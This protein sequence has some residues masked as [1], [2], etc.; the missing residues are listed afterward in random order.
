M[1][2]EMIIRPAVKEDAVAAARLLYDALHDVAHQLTGAE[3]EQEAV[4]VLEWFFRQEEG[5]LSYRQ[6]LVG[7][8]EGTVAGIIVLYGGDEAEAL[9]RPMIE[10]LRALKND[11]SITLDKETDED[12]F[13]ID[14]LSVSPQYGRRGVG[15][16]LMKAARERARERGY[17]KISLAVVTT[18]HGAHALYLR[19]GYVKDKEIMINGN[20]YYHMVKQ[21]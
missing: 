11:P 17:G 1:K 10:R 19:S 12:E 15:S 21:L 18:N 16:A 7:E 9:D 6:A 4:A 3:S 5:R 13:Y 14:T 2:E 20:V 8:V